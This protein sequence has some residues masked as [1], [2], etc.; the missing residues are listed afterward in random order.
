M[1]DL[2]KPDDGYLTPGEAAERLR[3]SPITLRKWVEK[4][5]LRACYTAGGHRRYSRR[6]VERLAAGRRRGKPMT[7]LIVDDDRLFANYLRELIGNVDGKAR[8]EYA[9]DGFEAGRKLVMSRPDLVL[10]DLVMPGLDGFSVCRRIKMEPGT[11]HIRVIALTGHPS[12]LNTQ[13]ILALGA[14][15]CFAKPVDTQALLRAMGL[16]GTATVE[17]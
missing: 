17:A 5:L 3:V 15:H 9:S 16:T 14:E 13:A 10:L 1:T 6:E 12:W 4:G 11:A 2:A 8:V 7:V